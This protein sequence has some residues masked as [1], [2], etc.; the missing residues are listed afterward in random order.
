MLA[1]Q[2]PVAQLQANPRLEVRGWW[3]RLDAATFSRT[4]VHHSVCEDAARIVETKEGAIHAAC[5]DGVGQGA[6]G[7]LAASSLAE[8]CVNAPPMVARD[9][10]ALSAWLALAE[11]VVQRGLR[12]VTYGEGAATLAALWLSSSGKG[13]LVRVGDCRAYRLRWGGFH[14]RCNVTQLTLDQTYDHVRESPPV[15]ASGSDPARMVG[16]EAM[17]IPELQHL[18]VAEGEAILL[19]SDGLHRSLDCAAIAKI[20]ACARKNGK[21]LPEI[22]EKLANAA[23]REGSEDD[24]TATIVYRR[25]ILGARAGFWLV[26]LLFSFGLAITSSSRGQTY[27]P[28][29]PNGKSGQFVH[30]YG[31]CSGSTS[32]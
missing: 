3:R 15:S 13:F 7:D 18:S 29:G 2:T 11:A 21:S 24:I 30:N 6:R 16:T 4:G 5:A 20:V 27:P 28:D 12:Q 23:H 32:R 19:C 8:H 31:H 22:C 26:L 14:G 10:S 9:A 1:V 17:G 25:R